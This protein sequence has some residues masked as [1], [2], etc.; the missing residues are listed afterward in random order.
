MLFRTL[1]VAL[2]RKYQLL[3]EYLDME[4]TVVVRNTHTIRLLNNPAINSTAIALKLALARRPMHFVFTL[5]LILIF[6][7][8][9]LLRATEVS[10]LLPPLILSPSL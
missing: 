4:C 1:H 6:I 10:S 7:T 5:L 3:G 9:Y 2:L 8:T